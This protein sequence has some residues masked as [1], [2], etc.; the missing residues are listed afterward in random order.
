MMPKGVVVDAADLVGPMAAQV[1]VSSRTVTESGG[2]VLVK[3]AA[4]PVT[5][6]AVGTSVSGAVS[7]LVVVG[8]GPVRT[9]AVAFLLT[10][11][12]RPWSSPAHPPSPSRS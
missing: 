12:G 8:D 9:V 4:A 3:V 11:F 5:L 6:R 10:P 1:K 7:V 2:S